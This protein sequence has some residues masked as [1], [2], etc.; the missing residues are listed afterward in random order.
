MLN[1]FKYAFI[2]VFP[3][4]GACEA[5][6]YIYTRM[7][8]TLFASAGKGDQVEVRYLISDDHKNIAW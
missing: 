1:R 5:R 7:L 2:D 6:G 3:H 8:E 4:S